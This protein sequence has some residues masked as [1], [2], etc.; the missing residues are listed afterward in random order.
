MHKRALMAALLLS[1]CVMGPD[2]ERPAFSLPQQWPWESAQKKEDSASETKPVVVAE[3]WGAFNDPALS[4]LIEEGLSAN[5]DLAVAAARVAEARAA[6]GLREANLFPEIGVQGAARRTRGSSSA[7]FG[8]LPGNAR[9][10]NDFGIAAVLNYEVSL[11][12]KLARETESASAL[13]AASEAAREAVRLAVAAD[14]ATGYFNLRALRMQEAIAMRTLEA[15]QAT[16]EYREKQYRHGAIDGLTYQQS[17]SEMESARAALPAIRQSRAQAETA[18]SVLLGRDPKTLVEGGFALPEPQALPEPPRVYAD[19]PSTLLERRPDIRAAEQNLISA[20]AAIGAAKADY[21]PSISLSSLIGLESSKTN[22]L[23]RSAARRWNFGAEIA[24]PVLDFGRVSSFVEGAEARKERA[25]A[26][27]GQTVRVAFKEALDAMNA[28]RNAAEQAL[29]QASR[30]QALAEALRLARLRYDAGYASHLDVLDAERGLFQ[31]ELERVSA[32][33]D[34]L[35]AAVTLIKAMGGGVGA[36]AEA[37]PVL[38][39]AAAEEAPAR[40]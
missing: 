21:F 34:R 9:P 32:E 27:Y 40:P 6:L 39:P 16:H 12:G 18:L 20:N 24:G 35:A 25:L 2:Y 38:P 22:T 28:E 33:R 5:A 7:S 10:Y 11:W 14:I 17:R 37:V 23:L 13:L 36:P 4:A 29:A 30:E 3:W 31:A 1:G 8:G 19:L 15:R 26:E